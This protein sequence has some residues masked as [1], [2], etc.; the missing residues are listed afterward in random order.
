MTRL[1]PVAAVLA[2]CAAPAAQAAPGD[3]FG[4]ALA[5]AARDGKPLLMLFQAEWCDPCNELEASI[6]E[7]RKG[8]GILA[9]VHLVR[10]DFD[11]EP[12]QSRSRQ[13]LI[14][15]LPTTLLL[16]ARVATGTSGTPLGYDEI[17][18]IE[19]F[20]DAP[21]WVATLEAALARNAPNPQAACD[22]WQRQPGTARL[23]LV[24]CAVAALRHARLTLEA[25]AWL[26]PVT[27]LKP[28]TDRERALVL[29]A[30]RALC[31]Y[32]LRARGDAGRCAELA[33]RGAAL[34]DVKRAGSFTYWQ[35]QCLARSGRPREAV[36]ALDTYL[37]RPAAGAAAAREARLLVADL[38]VHERLDPARA[39][40]E[41][42]ALL[43]TDPRDDEPHYLLARLLRDTG[44]PAEAR[45]AVAR[46]RALAPQKALY[47]HF[48]ERL[49][50]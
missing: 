10:Y 19:G 34:A 24:P 21:S 50:K 32:A 12:G 43:A 16:K 15:G 27:R 1:L 33:A 30:T 37:A 11:A 8:A 17:E 36:A 41:L 49:G 48:A 14:L 4:P 25:A 31:R 35:A 20:D 9:R 29:D 46:A 18:R 28:R 39:R 7:A 40:R 22:T 42:D 26:E 38:L 44:H 23:D 45:A 6:L 47:R 3:P 2:L 5:A 13:H